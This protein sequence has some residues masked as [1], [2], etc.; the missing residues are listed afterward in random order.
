METRFFAREKIKYLQYKCKSQQDKL[1]RTMYAF[2]ASYWEKELFWG[3]KGHGWVVPCSFCRFLV[4]FERLNFVIIKHVLRQDN[5]IYIVKHLFLKILS[6]FRYVSI[7]YRFQTLHDDS[8]DSKVQF[9]K[10]SN[11]IIVTRKSGS[12]IFVINSLA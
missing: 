11:S 5:F 8:Y 4:G 2:Y 7:A 12:V 10:R 6:L 3:V 1:F 9:R